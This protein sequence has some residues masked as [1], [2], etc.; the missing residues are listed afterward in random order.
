MRRFSLQFGLCLQGRRNK[1]LAFF[2]ELAEMT[3][4]STKKKDDDAD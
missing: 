1:W 4:S 2:V 3:F